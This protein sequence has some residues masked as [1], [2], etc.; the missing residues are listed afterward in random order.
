MT[1][2]SPITCHVL[3]ASTGKPCPGIEIRVQEYHILGKGM[4][5]FEPLAEG[6]TDADGRC[7]SP[8][9][10]SPEAKG[11]VKV[12]ANTLYKVV[13]KTE[14]YFKKQDTKCF[15][16]WVEVRWAWQI[17]FELDSPDEPYHIPLLIS[18]YSFTTYRG[19]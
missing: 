15:Y 6:T 16:P 4:A 8:V 1:T 18:P 13:F 12:K 19:S 9:P 14:E 11:V 7:M 10:I 2:K 3:D 17:T 5:M